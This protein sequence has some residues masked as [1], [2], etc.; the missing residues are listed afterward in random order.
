MAQISPYSHMGV[1]GIL[2][3]M[4]SARNPI[5]SGSPLQS[6]VETVRQPAER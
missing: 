2:I 6:I 5:L 4:D 1:S 3:R